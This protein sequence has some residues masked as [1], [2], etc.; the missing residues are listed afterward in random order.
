MDEQTR[1][2]TAKLAADNLRLRDE[3]K[4]LNRRLTRAVPVGAPSPTRVVDAM[5][6]GLERQKAGDLRI[7]QGEVTRMREIHDE[8]L[9]ELEALKKQY[10][11]LRE[12]W[13]VEHEAC[14]D[15]REKLAMSHSRVAE[16]RVGFSIPD[17]D[18]TLGWLGENV[19]GP[20]L[21]ADAAAQ[22]V[23][24]VEGE[25]EMLRASQGSVARHL[26]D[27]LRALQL[28]YDDLEIRERHQG[29]ELVN[30]QAAYA[31][32]LRGTSHWRRDMWISMFMHEMRL[33][34]GDADTARTDR[35]MS[36]SSADKAL[37]LVDDRFG[38][39]PLDTPKDTNE[40]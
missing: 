6:D 31:N 28:T 7:M 29:R 30:V 9:G 34:A 23:R 25:V 8:R 24:D 40:G 27:D 14:D 32:L 21:R 12:E 13:E 35:D 1:E 11:Q 26:Q 5:A 2:R 17:G 16:I 20:S 33:R 4:L 18:S 3:V 37:D 10:H 19:W 22:R 39:K 15:L 36:A 38:T